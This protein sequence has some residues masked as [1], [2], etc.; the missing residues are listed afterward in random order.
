MPNA[1]T[2]ERRKV[3][4]AELDAIKMATGCQW[5]GGCTNEITIPQQLEFAHLSQEDKEFKISA[6]TRHSPY[7]PANQ[8]RMKA[9]IAKCQ[10]L[11]LLHH[12]IE[13]VAGGHAGYRRG[14]TL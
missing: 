8:E 7:I 14:L 12:R 10:V 4:Q 1:N 3:W 9:E 13:T 11:C 6:F 2:P 5:P